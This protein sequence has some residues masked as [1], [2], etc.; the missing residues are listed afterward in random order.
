[1]S[2]TQLLTPMDGYTPP[3]VADFEFHGI[4]GI[5][6]LNKPLIQLVVSV[7]LICVLWVVATRKLKVVPTKGQYLVET[8]YEYVRNGIGRDIIGPGYRTW[9]PFLTATFFF[10]LVNN[11]FGE[12]FLFMF[13]AFSN[14]G[15]AYG[16]GIVVMVIYVAAGFKAHGWRFIY[17]SVVPSGVPWYLMILVVPIELISFYITRPFTL[18]VRIFANMFAGHMSLMVFM[19]GGGYLLT[20]AGNLLYNVSGFVSLVFSLVL[21]GLEL[22]IGFLQALIFTVLTASYIASS[23]SSEH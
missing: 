11:W 13:P 23:L 10:I 14:I 18:A 3:S 2:L 9:V 1:M 5:S 19:V 21:M 15:Y 16:L 20:Y 6:W 12:F 17:K 22:F 8:M 4:A 7:I